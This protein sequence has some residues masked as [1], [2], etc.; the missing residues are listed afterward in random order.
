MNMVLSQVNYL[1]FFLSVI[2]SMVLSI[3][4]FPVDFLHWRPE[5]MAL[6]VFYWVFRAPAHFGILTAWFLGLLLDLLEAS[7]LGLNAIGL[8][9]V[10]F[11]VLSTH[12]RMR[13]FPML[14]QVMMVFLVLGVSQMLVHFIKQSLAHSQ[15]TGFGYLLPVFTSALIWPLF[16]LLMDRMIWTK[17]Y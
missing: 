9:L 14:Q 1:S 13:M 6:L 2:L 15:L 4:L 10:A 17:R 12:Q 7:P 5:W 11:L 8:S 16:S 3:S